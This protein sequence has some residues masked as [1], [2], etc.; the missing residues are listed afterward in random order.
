MF[1]RRK[2]I[3]VTSEIINM[4]YEVSDFTDEEE[5][6]LAKEREGMNWARFSQVPG[7]P[8]ITFMITELC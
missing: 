8:V 6:L 5:Q 3:P 1:V 4:M 2:K 7:F